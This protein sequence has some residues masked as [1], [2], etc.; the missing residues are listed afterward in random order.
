[1]N[2]NFK[3]ALLIFCL[4]LFNKAQ[5]QNLGG[6]KKQKP[7]EVSGNLS[8][9]A[10]IY[11]TT[12]DNPRISPF[13]YFLNGSPT[14]SI[15][16]V[17][18]PLSFT[19][20]N[21]QFSYSKPFQRYGAS[22]YYKWIKLHLGHR[23][24]NFSQYSMTGQTFLGAGV[25][26]TPG[27]FKFVA[28]YG[29]FENVFATRDPFEIGVLPIE[30]FDRKGYGLK[31]GYGGEKA[32]F[33]I[34]VLK[35]GDDSNFSN[36][37]LTDTLGIKPRENLVISPE[38]KATFFER[39]HIKSTLS[40]SVIT[41]NKNAS[42]GIIDDKIISQF[43]GI[44][45]VN[46]STKIALA[47]DA[48]ADI[49]FKKGSLGVS[50]QRIEPLYESLGLY[51]INNDF[52]NYTVNGSLSLFKKRVQL[53][54]SQGYQQNNLTHLRKT[55]DLRKIGSYSISA[56][57]KN[58]ININ[59][60]YGNY[61]SN[62]EAGF[63]EVNDT[64]RLALINKNASLNSSYRWKKKKTDHSISF[65]LGGQKF[66]DLNPLNQLSLDN[67]SSYSNLNYRINLSPLKLSLR[68]GLNYS[69]HESITQE[70]TRIGV[71]VSARKKVFDDKLQV[72]LAL[73]FQKSN[74]DQQNDGAVYKG[75]F[76][77]SQKLDDHN[78]LSLRA[79]LINRSSIIKE[80]FSDYR[81]RF[82][83]TYKF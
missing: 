29:T 49:S 51:G 62:Q 2:N 22:P 36:L 31:I 76:S 55:T 7:F 65:T 73:S 11:G 39:I 19:Y 34:S 37:I 27:K 41:Q 1:M 13:S 58:G 20:S 83:Y 14:F 6:F 44:L 18:V 82:S 47:G 81:A 3:I 30:T 21:Q 72:K 75:N 26:L 57:L 54:A 69:S 4:A 32:S 60:Q 63:V 12:R 80:A 79:S 67:K 59:A 56:F 77:L 70:T 38:F 64:L 53:N 61:Q 17:Q 78:T 45:E 16:G 28:F 74:V 35:I 43:K 15:Y 42:T 66:K 50:Y 9:S 48:S 40:A 10:N 23:S 8:I 46:Q 33:D 25:E 68:G 24:L 5:A 71:S 52:E